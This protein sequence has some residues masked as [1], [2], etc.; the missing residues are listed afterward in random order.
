MFLDYKIV[1]NAIWYKLSGHKKRNV[2]KSGKK[3]K[4]SNLFRLNNGGK[5]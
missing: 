3:E 2:F 1:S 5:N 4:E